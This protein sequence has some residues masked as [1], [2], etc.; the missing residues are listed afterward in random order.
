MSGWS[1][2]NPSDAAYTDCC[3]TN[4]GL[5]SY[6]C[7]TSL[8][9]NKIIN[10]GETSSFLNTNSGNFVSINCSG[11][12][13]HILATYTNFT[14]LSIDY[15]VTWL[16]NDSGGGTPITTTGCIKNNMDKSGRYHI[17]VGNNVTRFST[18]FG[19]TFNSGTPGFNISDVCYN[20]DGSILYACTTTSGALLKGIFISTDYGS[21]WTQTYTISRN[22]N[23]IRCNDRG[24][25][26]YVSVL[27][28]G[29]YIS[30]DYGT[31]FTLTGAPT[32][33]NNQGLAVSG[34]GEVSSNVISGNGYTDS[35][36][37]TTNTGITYIAQDLSSVLTTPAPN[38]S[39]I[40]M[41]QTGRTIYATVNGDGVYKYIQPGTCLL[42]N[43]EIETISGYVKIQDIKKGDLIKTQS[44]KYKP[45]L[46]LG[47]GSI[48]LNYKNNE[49]ETRVVLKD[50]FG[51][52]QP[53]QDL[54]MTRMHALL[55]SG[56]IENLTNERYEKEKKYYENILKIEGYNK[57]LA[58]HC[59]KCEYTNFKEMQVK[60]NGKSNYYN[61]VLVSND[62]NEEF[63]IFA[64]GILVETCSK[65]WF[66]K[67]ELT[68]IY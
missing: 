26:I 1:K 57:L 68:K 21:T 29:T 34:N 14:N 32:A 65:N 12:E 45:I 63:G 55:F 48:D 3:T 16:L 17:C 54:Y 18:D 36:Y 42:E 6:V 20:N 8:K 33:S 60:F 24:D 50:T 35:V 37:I 25:K 15:G 27:S 19:S 39:S 11:N 2:L 13:Q 62:D 43:T 41:N 53:I 23:N 51:K 31:T 28:G 7:G 47:S 30:L 9:I 5:T 44:G 46:H 22:Y 64:E 10:N 40:S 56:E 66:Y 4:D 67:S 61:I 38:W 49:F 59:N 58:L 52:N